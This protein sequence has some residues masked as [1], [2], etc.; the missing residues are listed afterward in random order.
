MHIR[1]HAAIDQTNRCPANAIA[2]HIEQQ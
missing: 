1:R 2:L